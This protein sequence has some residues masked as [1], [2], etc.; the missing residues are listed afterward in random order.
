MDSFSSAEFNQSPAL[1]HNKTD[2]WIPGSDKVGF[3]GLQSLST[4]PNW[5]VEPNDYKV[6]M[7][8]II[9]LYLKPY[10]KGKVSG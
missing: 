3:R 2:M 5:W 9:P 1:L 8:P 6:L 4:D 7:I 10:R